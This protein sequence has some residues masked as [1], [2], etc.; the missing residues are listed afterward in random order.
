MNTNGVLS[1]G[2]PY[3]S[4]SSGRLNFTFVSSPPLIAPFWDDIDITKGGSI[5]YR[6]DNTSSTADQV[7]LD[8]YNQFPDVDSFYPSLVFV[9]TWDRVAAY[10]SSLEGLVNTFQIVMASDGRQTFVK[11][12]YIDIQ[13]GGS[14]TLIGVSAGNRVNFITHPASGLSSSVLSLNYTTTMYKVDSKFA[15]AG[16]GEVGLTKLT[17]HDF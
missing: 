14:D 10:S 7:Q 12:H 11:F 2:W 17:P 16:G 3:T 8:V 1:F 4:T 13:W 6:L 15:H 9:A 5:Y